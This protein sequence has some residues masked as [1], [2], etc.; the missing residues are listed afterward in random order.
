MGCL[1]HGMSDGPLN[2]YK[3]LFILL[4]RWSVHIVLPLGC[5][6]VIRLQTCHCEVVIWVPVSPLSIESTKT[7][8]GRLDRS[9]GTL[10]LL[11]ERL[12][13]LHDVV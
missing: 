10:Y 2:V 11:K 8:G 3:W 9:V 6:A 4:L 1:E 5:I 13:V 7:E 12:C